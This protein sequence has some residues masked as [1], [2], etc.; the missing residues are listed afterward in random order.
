[1]ATEMDEIAAAHC[2]V[3]VRR[4]FTD[5]DLWTFVL[6]LPA[7]VKFP[8]MRTKS[9]LRDGMRGKLPDAILDRTDKTYFD[10]YHLSKADY[11]VLRRWLVGAGFRLPGIDYAALEKR[12][13]A[14]DMTVT[15]LQW[16]RDLVRIH[17]FVDRSALTRV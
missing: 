5:V 10:S 9:L 14:G 12:I 3:D 7:E 17:A 1:M 16:A 6:S 13:E 15:E 4:P 11:P 2:G 8:D